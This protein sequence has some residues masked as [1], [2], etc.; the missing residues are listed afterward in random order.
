MIKIKR[1]NFIRLLLF[2]TALPFGFCGTRCLRL[3][4]Q[5]RLL[6]ETAPMALRGNREVLAAR[7]RPRP[8]QASRRTPPRRSA[9]TVAMAAR[10]ASLPPVL[11]PGAGGHGGSATSSATALNKTGSASATATSTGGNGGR[12]GLPTVCIHAC[13]P[14]RPAAVVWRAQQVRLSAAAPV[15]STAARLRTA[16]QV[17]YA[18]RAPALV[19]LPPPQPAL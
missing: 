15:R 19:D 16:A 12:G 2:A 13:I 9:A 1:H 7:P 10:A 11:P 5:S 17:V 6:V 14:G 8:R 18:D 3:L 4:Q